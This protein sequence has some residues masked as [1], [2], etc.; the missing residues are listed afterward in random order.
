MIIFGSG[1]DL[2]M[3]KNTGSAYGV[4]PEDSITGESTIGLSTRGDPN[5]MGDMTCTFL[6]LVRNAFVIGSHVS[7]L[8][9]CGVPPGDS[10]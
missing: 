10:L 8:D 2:S 4:E 5:A 9:R 6:N 7:V 3:A 1:W